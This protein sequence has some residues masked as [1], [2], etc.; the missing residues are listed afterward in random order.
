MTGPLCPH[1]WICTWSFST[2]V[3]AVSWLQPKCN[4]LSMLAIFFPVSLPELSVLSGISL[5]PDISPYSLCPVSSDLFPLLLFPSLS[6][7]PCSLNSHARFSFFM[8][9]WTILV[10]PFFLLCFVPFS[11][12]AVSALPHLPFPC[13][14]KKTCLPVPIYMPHPQSSSC[15]ICVAVV[16]FFL[17]GI[18]WPSK[19]LLRDSFCLWLRCMDLEQDVV[20]PNV[21]SL[22]KCECVFPGTAKDLCVRRVLS[23]AI[24]SCL[25]FMSSVS[26]PPPSSLISGFCLRFFF[27]FKVNS[28]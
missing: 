3:R 15:P 20:F 6:L 8:S 17:R 10:L 4:H 7:W 2:Q 19:G 5:F 24:S 12:V 9:S 28:S 11:P 23:F 16:Q 21:D 27:L 14:D 22:A 1:P 13:G 25:K 18:P 26:T